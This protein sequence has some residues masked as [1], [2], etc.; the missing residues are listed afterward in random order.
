MATRTR[1]RKQSRNPAIRPAVTLADIIEKY[2]CEHRCRAYLEELRWPN[3][4]E[5]PRCECKS[6]SRIA[7]RHQYDCNECRYQFSVI[8]GTMMHDTHLP[9]WKWFATVYMMCESKKGVSANQIKRMIGVAYKTSWYLCHR[10]RDAMSKANDAAPKL[11][12]VVEADETLVGGKAKGG[13]RGYT[14]NKVTVAV[15][16]ERDGG[17]RIK[18]I[19]DRTRATLH[20]FLDAHVA[21]DATAIYTD[22]WEAY[23]GIATDDTKHE[24]VNHSAEEW[25]RGL[26][27]TNTAE[28]VWSL[29][30]RSIIGAFHHVSHKHLDRYLD[31]LEW[32]F[33]NRQ[34]EYLFR[35]TLLCLLE[36]GNLEYS[37]LIA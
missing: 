3:G 34:N 23:K 20:A 5:C 6:I 4:V 13:G 36:P 9:L 31:E 37:E 17:A 15:A 12:D 26:V 21:D 16:V 24:T 2:G 28:S 19:P 7:D 25:V 35:D 22:E 1:K 14:G 10:I 11:D 27:H 30:K 8:S 29:L 33:G 18:V 32:R